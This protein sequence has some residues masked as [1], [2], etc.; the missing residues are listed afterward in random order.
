MFLFCFFLNAMTTAIRLVFHSLTGD[1]RWARNR[2]AECGQWCVLCLMRYVWVYFLDSFEHRSKYEQ[3]GFLWDSYSYTNDI[4]FCF[5]VYFFEYNDHYTINTNLLLDISIF[6][7]GG[8]RHKI[9]TTQLDSMANGRYEHMDQLNHFV[10][11]GT[12]VVLLCMLVV[13]ICLE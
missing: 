6:W 2:G 10:G 13:T 8:G 3:A 9:E 5:D 1:Q 4:Y 12:S 7:T 11:S